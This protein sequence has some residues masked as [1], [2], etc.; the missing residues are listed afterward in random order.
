MSEG[1]MISFADRQLDGLYDTGGFR[2][3]LRAFGSAELSA[4][5]RSEFD[6]AASEHVEFDGTSIAHAFYG[7]AFDAVTRSFAALVES[8]IDTSDPVQWLRLR[9]ML[10][11]A[12]RLSTMP[13]MTFEDCSVYETIQ[14]VAFV[15]DLMTRV[16]CART[17]HLAPLKEGSMAEL[18]GRTASIVSDILCG[19]VGAWLSVIDDLGRQLVDFDGTARWQLAIDAYADEALSLYE[20][21][22][23]SLGLPSERFVR[24]L[25]T[26]VLVC[27]ATFDV[28]QQRSWVRVFP[29]GFVMPPRELYARSVN[30][31]LL[32]EL[33]DVVKTEP[34]AP[35]RLRGFCGLFGYSPT[36]CVAMLPGELSS[37]LCDAYLEMADAQ[38]S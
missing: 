27:A 36:S 29:D 6:A 9:H 32:S 10:V 26:Q 16:A 28:L 33:E 13:S 17:R 2:A 25:S 23:S 11:S 15:I 35:G 19:R 5:V 20:S 37:T 4:T 8:G 22:L 7:D 14:L 3:L 34:E 21:R 38:A 24:M 1:V 31:R 30:E 12:A 18:D